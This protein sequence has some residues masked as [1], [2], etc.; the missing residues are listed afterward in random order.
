MALINVV[1][2]TLSEQDLVEFKNYKYKSGALTPLDI[3]LAPKFNWLVEFLPI[4]LAPNLVTH[5][6]IAPFW[7]FTILI[8]ILYPTYDLQVPGWVLSCSG[9]AIAFYVVM[10]ALDGKQARRTGSSSPLGQLVDHGLD[11]GTVLPYTV[12]CTAILLVT[13]TSLTRT[14]AWSIQLLNHGGLFLAQWQEHHTGEMPTAIGAIGVTEIGFGFSGLA[15]FTGFIDP[16]SLRAFFRTQ[17]LGIEL[18]IFAGILWLGVGSYLFGSSIIITIV[19]TYRSGHLRRALMDMIP[20]LFLLIPS[21]FWSLECHARVGTSLQVI[22]ASLSLLYTLPM[23]ISSMARRDYPILQPTLPAYFALMWSSRVLHIEQVVV[24]V[25]IAACL[26]V[27]GLLGWSFVVARQ[28]THHLNI[29]MF[30]I[31]PKPA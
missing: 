9:I 18:E 30:T 28:I 27:A 21:F 26:S 23:I 29:S 6:G 20:I 13:E 12:I 31:K 1:A 5:L 10:D 22:V 2:P 15:F 7:L 19:S 16:L 8:M 3:F 17:L 24:L 4:W 14:I 25:R 11:C